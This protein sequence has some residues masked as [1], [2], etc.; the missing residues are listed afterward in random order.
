MDA[1]HS[2]IFYVLAALVLASAAFTAFSSNLVHAAFSLL[3]TFF[4]LACLYVQLGADFV[5]VSQVLIYVGGILVLLLFGVMFTGSLAGGA[6]RQTI[7]YKWGIGLLVLLF[8]MLL[9]IIFSAPWFTTDNPQGKTMESTV[10][11]IGELLMT[12]YLLPF[13]IA[14]LLLLI[15]LIGAVVL[16]RG[17]T[18]TQQES[19][20]GTANT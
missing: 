4:G 8:L 9:P 14:S 1:L 17:E 12:T 15:A 7:Q 6:L 10:S 3:F 13:E 5:G 19:G 16:A 2:L 18:K 20:S 11:A